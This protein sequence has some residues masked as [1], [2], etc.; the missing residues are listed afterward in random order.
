MSIHVGSD[1]S[2]NL[3]K[4]VE[5]LFGGWETGC[6]GIKGWGGDR[7]SLVVRQRYLNG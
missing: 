5:S 3:L 4:I 7:D 6:R 1:V 2:Y